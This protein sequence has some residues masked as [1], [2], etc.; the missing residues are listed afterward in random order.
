MTSDVHNAQV[1]YLVS[2]LPHP[3]MF[4]IFDIADVEVIGAWLDLPECEC[5]AL[6]ALLS[7]PER[8]R[9]DR[10]RSN[11]D[12]RH[13][14]IARGRLR[15]L[16]AERLRIEPASIGITATDH[17]KPKLAPAHAAAGLEFNLSHSAALAV[18][19][20]ARGR[21]IGIDIE[22]MREIPDA[23]DLAAR[24]FSA[25]EAA[26]YRA[27]PVSR[28]NLAFLACWTRKEAFIKAL[29]E[30]LSHPLDAFDVTVDPDEPGRITR[31][32]ERTGPALDW[33]LT[34][35]RPAPSYIGAL[36][37]AVPAGG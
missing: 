29:G 26:A 34:C 5:E 11:G 9:A 3:E 16:L 23:D 8:Q 37:Q 14:I 22:Q 13:Y 35:F 10:F 12:R 32:G 19:A 2:D 20:F 25:A 6:Y 4:R 15:Q 27:L 17:G 18:Y 30:G 7:P 33:S 21:P 31:I 36:V 28:R 1:E 24:Y